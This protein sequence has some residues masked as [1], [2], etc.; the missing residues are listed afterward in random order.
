MPSDEAIAAARRGES[1][2]LEA[3]Y[4]NYAPQVLGY[5]RGQHVPEPED[6]TGDVFVSVVRNLPDFE[7]G[8][9]D[10]RRW[11]FTI[12]HRRVVDSFRRGSRRRESPAEPAG[13]G[14]HLDAGDDVAERV[15]TAVTLA[16]LVAALDRLTRDQRAVVLLRVLADLSV[17]E[18]AA[19][20]GKKV[21]AVKTLQRRA[22][23]ALQGSLSVETVS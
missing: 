2:A 4:R 12:A 19:I 13:L 22:L 14:E 16:P 1:W 23:S 3:V 5:L 15:T 9:S 20:L 8:E 21:G 17:A 6:V 7:G 18:T 11:L 10:F